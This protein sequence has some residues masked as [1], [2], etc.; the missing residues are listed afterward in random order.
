MTAPTTIDR[1]YPLICWP[2]GADKD[3]YRARPRRDYPK[4]TDAQIDALA[5]AG[6][7][8]DAG[9]KRFVRA[10]AFDGEAI[11]EVEA[12]KLRGL[13]RRMAA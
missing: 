9:S 6:A 12:E 2:A 1:G 3:H 5:A 13:G 11:S 10:S 4:A 8:I 7:M